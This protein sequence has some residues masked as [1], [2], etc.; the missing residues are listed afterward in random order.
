[1]VRDSYTWEPNVHPGQNGQVLVHQAT[2]RD[3]GG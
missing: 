3:I 2:D 1:M